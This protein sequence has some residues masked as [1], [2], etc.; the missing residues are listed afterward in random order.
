MNSTELRCNSVISNGLASG[1]A[2]YS[3]GSLQIYNSTILTNHAAGY[4]ASNAAFNILNV[5]TPV[6]EGIFKTV[7]IYIP[8]NFNNNNVYRRIK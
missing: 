4:P 5:T 1:G 3:L 6:L 7:H 2:I 8:I